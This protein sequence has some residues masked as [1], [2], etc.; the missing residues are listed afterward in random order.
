M[1]VTRDVLQWT[2]V[3]CLAYVV[4]VYGAY[5]AMI[6]YSMIEERLRRQRRVF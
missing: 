5:G 6:G 4:T 2:V 3:V 1:S